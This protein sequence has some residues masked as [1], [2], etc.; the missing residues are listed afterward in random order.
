MT[1]AHRASHVDRLP[2]GPDPV[3]REYELALLDD[4]TRR[5]AAGRPAL[6]MLEGP[7][8][9]GKSTLL[10][11]LVS[12]GR[13]RDLRVLH[14]RAGQQGPRLPFGTAHA[15]LA[16]LDDGSLR[17]PL[18]DCRD[19][20]WDGGTTTRPQGLPL[21]ET[22]DGSISFCVVTE[23]LE[24]VRSATANGPLM[25]VVDNAEEADEASLHFF[26][27][28]ARRMGG[29]PLLLALARRSGAHAPALNEVAALPL[30]QVLRPRPLTRVGI[31]L[32]IQGL[33]GTECDAS[34]QECC[35]AATNGNPLL[36]TRLLTELYEKGLPHTI[37]HASPVSGHDGA[38]FRSPATSLLRRQQ[39]VTVEVARALA[40]L[41]D[42]ATSETCA[43]LAH[44]DGTVFARSILAL[45]SGGLVASDKDGTWSFAHSLLRAAVLGDMSE[46]QRS[47]AHG[48]AA[49]L[50]HDGGAS[51]AD[52]ADHLCRSPATAAQPWART[53]LREAAREAMLRA[54]P[55]RAVELLRP[56][57]P[58]GAEEDCE[59]SLLVELGVAERWVDAE[60]SIR[61]LTT[62]LERPIDPELRL[63]ALSVLAEALAR[64]GQVVSAVGLL[65]RIY[66]DTTAP[67]SAIAR[68]QL[69]E[70]QVLM[71][72][73]CDRTA[74]TEL[75]KNVTFDLMLP[76]DTPDE[77]ALLTAR[78]VISVARLDRVAQAVAAVRTVVSRG[79]VATD[80]VFLAI[81]GSALLYS[82]RPHEAERVYRQLLDGT[83]ALLDQAFPSLLGLQGEAHQ[84]LG[85]LGEALDTTA[86]ALE[87]VVVSR[88]TPEE[89]VPLAVRIH[90]LL[91]SGELAEASLLEAEIA[92][93]VADYAWQWNE[94]LCARG[95]LHLA[96]GDPKLALEHLEESGRRQAEWQRI[97]PAVSP[98]WYWTGR[99]HLALGDRHAARALAEE[100]AERARA[101][102]LP[103]ALG[104]ALDLWAD[105]LENDERPA[106]LEEAE[107]ILM[108]TQAAL[109]RARV[110]VARGKMLQRLGHQK[111]AREVL[112]QGWEE[113]YA[114]GAW[115]LHGIAHRALLATGARPRRPV[116]HGLGA[117]TQSEAQVARLAADGKKNA[118][119]AETLF[120]TQ[121]T[122]EVHLTSVYRKLGLSGR[123]EL[124]DVMKTSGTGDGPP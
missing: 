99:A 89:A 48:R 40:V 41:G 15:L 42:G 101:S 9:I 12:R 115:P 86:T 29:L 124:K 46:E 43:R 4:L 8:G 33:I 96:K 36:V 91:D 11:A 63:Q 74:Y 5:T 56:C 102:D 62:A 23:L 85:A 57:V 107:Q 50:L 110:R 64:H 32:L 112:R 108:G 111:A 20:S 22:D 71:A 75:L 24:V 118:L 10:E 14:T 65:G 123:R 13:A 100:A 81:A 120:V 28:T 52:V 69:M 114:I 116:S 106:L 49:R 90:A 61:H 72:A 92:D 122:V 31:D 58:E 98:W 54:S 39:K 73:T 51:A 88:A 35:L 34:V 119:I 68:P 80:G 104:S 16:D 37:T 113:A 55:R 67:F 84:R 66:S 44:L 94:V 38:A 78:S 59:P 25:I 97:S 87:N 26:A 30:C 77:R 79:A 83:D 1:S 21:H 70:A 109:V 76:G 7:D 95:R 3:E 53:V 60:A 2:D 117:L 17:L 47:T 103:C 19:A 121:R 93:P 18:A 82:D 6:V 45:V 105:A 27:H